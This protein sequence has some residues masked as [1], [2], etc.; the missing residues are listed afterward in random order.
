MQKKTFSGRLCFLLLYAW[1]SS[2]TM[3][4]ADNTPIFHSFAFDDNAILNSMSDNGQWAVAD[5]ANPSNSLLR[6]NPRLVDLSH[7]QVTELCAGL[8]L[9]AVSSAQANDVT[10][11]GHIVVGSLNGAP[12][13][14][15]RTSGQW[16]TLPIA[17]NAG[18]GCALSVTPDGHYAVGMMTDK[19]NEYMEQPA[20]W[21]L[22]T[23]KLLETPGLPTKDMAHEDKGQNR[24]LQISADG[25]TILGCMSI[26]YLPTYFDLGGHFEY[27]YHVDT[28]TYV[29]MGFTETESGRWQAHA[30][31]LYY[32]PVSRMSN[33]GHYVSGC[34]YIVQENTDS[35]FPTEGYFPFLYD[36]RTDNLEVYA[37]SEDNGTGGWIAHN[38]GC[39]LG[40]TPVGSPYRE[41]SV[42]NGNYW[43]DFSLTLRSKYGIDFNGKTGFENTG[44]PLTIS[45]DGKSV[46][47]LV[48]PYSS[49]VVQLPE[50]VSTIANGINLLGNY[51]AYPTEG[52]GLSKLQNV[53]ITFN[54]PVTVIDGKGS[55]AEIR[56]AQGNTLYTSLAIKADGTGKTVTV[57]FRKGDLEGGKNYS[58]FIPAGTVHISGDE[59]RTNGDIS[60]A[61]AGR[62]AVPVKMLSA[63]PASDTPIARMDATTSPVILTFDTQVKTSDLPVSLYLDED[64]TLVCPLL[65][66]SYQNQVAVYPSTAT[67]LYKGGTYSVRIPA[68]AITDLNG[69]N[70]NEELHLTYEGAYER[71]VSYDDKVL[72][73]ADFNKGLLPMLLYDGDKLTPHEEMQAMGFA[74]P[75]NYPWWVVMDNENSQDMAAG[76]HSCYSPAGQSDDWMVIPQTYLPDRL[77]TL[78]FQGQSYRH[79]KTDRLKVYVYESDVVYNLLTKTLTDRI[80]TE[81]TL[82]F[83]EVLNPGAT[84]GGIDNEWTDYSVSLANHAGKNVY[85]AF[86]NDNTDQ[87]LVMVDNVS[88]LHNLPYLVT[89]DHAENVINQPSVTVK[90]RVTIDTDEETYTSARLTLKDSEGHTVS[91]ITESALELKR[92]DALSFSFPE[93]LPLTVGVE[94]TFS[95]NICMNDTENEVKGSVKNLAFEPQKNVVL[96]E[97]TGMNCTNCPLGILAVEKLQ[98]LYGNRF[99]PVCLHNYPGDVLGSGSDSYASYL[100]FQAAPTGMVH[101]S[102]IISA[103]MVSLPG[104]DYVFSN[105]D[106][107]KLW[108]D[109]VQD[110]FAKPAEAEVSATATLSADGHTVSVPATVRFALHTDKRNLNL[111]VLLLED[112]VLGYQQNNLSG[113]TDPDLGEWGKGG[114]YASSNV[115]PYYHEN[116]VRSWKG[117]SPLG[118]GGLLPSTW[119]AGTA[120]TAPLNIDM[121]GTVSKASHAKVV[122]MLFDANSQQLVNACVSPVQVPEGISPAAAADIRILPTRTGFRVQLD[123][124][125]SV[126]AYS[127]DGRLLAKGTGQGD[128][129]LETGH[130]G[131]LIVK[132]TTADGKQ[133]VRK[134]A[135]QA[136]MKP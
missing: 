6:M 58:L 46:C 103:P 29:P 41:W 128:I 73:S 114:I 28:Q 49:Y 96:E 25:K 76:S 83:D 72:F 99:I 120:F 107:E 132:V 127:T 27:I 121:A 124:E 98:A 45:D 37:T 104:N 87:S 50:Q 90:G 118:T 20:M 81:G 51:T 78:H 75:N 123:G 92:G 108:L 8:D 133:A 102:G 134:F 93:P 64:N 26:S 63:V 33:N 13:Y 47:V 2:L 131:L 65:M 88:I 44:T 57:T 130:C 16:T 111:L 91:E 62:D 70:A 135:R 85:V 105:P 109:H 3:V 34:A 10:D 136:T 54:R 89:F 48:D 24:F 129:Q 106:G 23:G 5:A 9:A 38:D 71:E 15:N 119:E 14:W 12:A 116:V 113:Q 32:F 4:T 30:D 7:N 40:A 52:A 82:V 67:Y 95:V 122:V 117:Q 56:D 36:T 43:V 11:D 94:N 97:Y 19:D 22:T 1:I 42:K 17:G 101:R 84:E 115:F 79:T 125:A 66:T 80:R 126:E 77:C 53:S 35:E 55:A 69:D 68:G 110:E 100:G 39:M 21:D 60:I 59:D 112:N 31:G 74:D 86:L 61:Y 18:S